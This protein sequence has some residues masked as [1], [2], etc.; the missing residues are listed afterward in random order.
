[1]NILSVNRNKDAVKD[2]GAGSK[3]I[4]ASGIYPVTIKFASIDVSKSGAKSVNFNIDYNGNSQ[5]IYGPYITN[6]A[7]D[8]LEI[9]LG[10]VRDRLGVI[11]GVDG[12]LTIEEETHAVGKDNKEQEFAVIT[13]FSDLQVQMRIQMEYSKYNGNISE[14]KVIKNFFREDGASA[15]EILAIENGEEAEIGKRLAY[16]T[17][18]FATNITYRDDLT[19]SDVSKFKENRKSGGKN[20]G[21]TPT[22]NTTAANKLF[23]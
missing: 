23:S 11:A 14:K 12:D 7:G 3:F 19:E 6:K 1:M 16:E 21:A 18:K 5:T 20:S 8:P 13:D 15:E 10:L 2:G 17:E 9:G 22:V 4:N